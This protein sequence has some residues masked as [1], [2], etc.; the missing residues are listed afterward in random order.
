[1]LFKRS[2]AFPFR[3][4]EPAEHDDAE[5]REDREDREDEMDMLR[6]RIELAREKLITR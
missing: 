1:M 2:G 4:V 3:D 6:R 5:D